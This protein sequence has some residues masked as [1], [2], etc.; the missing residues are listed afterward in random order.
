M[1]P[2]EIE[3]HRTSRC[4]LGMGIFPAFG[5]LVALLVVLVM[6]IQTTRQTNAH[7]EREICAKM[8]DDTTDCAFTLAVR[9]LAIGS[10]MS[11][12][13]SSRGLPF[14]MPDANVYASIRTGVSLSEKLYGTANSASNPKIF[15]YP[16]VAHA[17]RETWESVMTSQYGFN[18]SVSDFV[19]SESH[20]TGLSNTP[21]TAL[22]SARAVPAPERASYNPL[23]AI[24]STSGTGE[25]VPAAFARAVLG[26][27]ELE[28]SRATLPSIFASRLLEDRKITARSPYDVSGNPLV[29]AG[30]VVTIPYCGVVGCDDDAAQVLGLVVYGITS[31]FWGALFPDHVEIDGLGGDAVKRVDRSRYAHHIALGGS[32]LDLE[33]RCYYNGRGVFHTIGPFLLIAAIGLLVAVVILVQYYLLDMRMQYA[34]DRSAWVWRQRRILNA[35]PDAIAN[36]TFA[37]DANKNAGESPARDEEQG[38]EPSR[39]DVVFNVLNQHGDHGFHGMASQ[40]SLEDLS[41]ADDLARLRAL[42]KDP[43]TRSIEFE[44]RLQGAERA[45]TYDVAVNP[46]VA[47]GGS[48]SHERIC[49]FRDVSVRVQRE[50]ES[51]RAACALVG[52]QESNAA[53]ALLRAEERLSDN[54]SDQRNHESVASSRYLRKKLERADH[55]SKPYA[56]STEALDSIVRPNSLEET[57][58]NNSLSRE[59]S[60][61]I[62]YFRRVS[63][64]KKIAI[65]GQVKTDTY[66]SHEMKNRIIVLLE[67]SRLGCS[68]ADA[69]VAAMRARFAYVTALAEDLLE[70]TKRKSVL[71]HLATG[72]YDAR[73]EEADIS[74]LL[75]T[76]VSRYVDAGRAVVLTPTRGAAAASVARLLLDPMLLNII[77]DNVL[78]NAFKYGGAA[79]PPNVQLQIDP[80]EHGVVSVRLAVRNAAGPGHAHLLDL[81]EDELNSIA[82]RDGARA[83]GQLGAATSAGDGFPMAVASAKA[84]G[85]TL[86]LTL[87]AR[88][89]CATLSLPRVLL[90]ASQHFGAMD[91]SGLS[92]ALVDDSVPARKMMKRKMERAFDSSRPPIV[93]GETHASI[94]A[95]P[96]TVFKDDTDVIFVD[97]NFGD[98]HQTKV[99]TDLVREIRALDREDGCPRRLIF[100]VSA[101]DAP[102]DLILYLAAG[103]DGHISKNTSIKQIRVEV[104]RIASDSD[105]FQGRVALRLSKSSASLATLHF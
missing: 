17:D 7:R 77:L 105:R 16:T 94:E 80:V 12:V 10:T 6:E 54:V 18:V 95:F 32:Y 60:R 83:H 29:N 33:F 102:D 79:Q 48:K 49:V 39:E 59:T 41:P 4:L 53:K 51:R 36:M 86:R 64:P 56:F 37:E 68:D 81:G 11:S 25:P 28:N 21:M 40:I 61:E 103:A 58:R 97:Q 20:E 46:L 63:R 27:D 23:S 1:V 9:A 15:W 89:I 14:L 92:M 104:C 42:F 52:C 87:Q 5:L 75:A 69:P 72:I 3:N 98:V 8:R 65:T 22:N 43:Q 91:I 99:G 26:R 62:E 31:Q 44:S 67:C 30:L 90:E 73:L 55:G 88:E 66:L 70:T 34:R 84:L 13:Q 100:V 96:Q 101:N 38:L 19:S 35:M 45:V 85:G 82:A 78:S 2:D 24:W 50:E 47:S 57:K 93:A 74:R 71:L 76:R